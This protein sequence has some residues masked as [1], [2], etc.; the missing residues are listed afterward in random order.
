[1]GGPATHV[2]WRFNGNPVAGTNYSQA[3]II[4]D[5][6]LALY[7]NILTIIPNG[8]DKSGF[9]CCTVS[10]SRGNASADIFVPG[11]YSLIKKVLKYYM[12]N[13]LGVVYK[14]SFML[15]QQKKILSK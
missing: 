5:L 13:I 7:E 11:K 15:Q 4:L 14:N 12:V 2:S 1:V 6:G 3:Q 9:F 10:N 8:E